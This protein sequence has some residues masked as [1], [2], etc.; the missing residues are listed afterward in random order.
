MEDGEQ[1]KPQANQGE[2]TASPLSPNE[3]GSGQESEAG[4]D[5]SLEQSTEK[6]GGGEEGTQEQKPL[7]SGKDGKLKHGEKS[8]VRDFIRKPVAKIF[9]HKSTE[10]AEALKQGKTRSKSLDRLE[11]PE[12]CAAALDQTDD[13]QATGEAHR[14]AHHSTKHMKRWHSF[15]K[16]MA[17]KGQRRAAEDHKDMDSAEGPGS[18]TQLEAEALETAG[19]L[20]HHGQKRWKLKRSWT[21]QGLKRD[22]SV[23]GIHKPKASDK[24]SLGKGEEAPAN[25]DQGA[26]ASS[27]EAKP[28]AEGETQEREEE[29]GS[30][31]LR[32]KSVDHHAN[33]IWTNFKKRVIP[34]SKRASDAGGG[35]GDEATG[36]HE[37][38]EEATGKSA[39]T[40]RTHFN[41]AVSLKNFIMRKGKSASVDLG[42][43][44]PAEQKE[45]G[46]ESAGEASA[47][48]PVA[49]DVK[50][51]DGPANQAAVKESEAPAAVQNGGDEK[52][53]AVHA[54]GQPSASTDQE[55]ENPDAKEQA[56]PEPAS[57]ET[58]AHEENGSLGAGCI[59]KGSGTD[60]EDGNPKDIVVH[61]H[62]TIPH[63]DAPQETANQGDCNSHKASLQA[64]NA[65]S[66]ESKDEA[67]FNQEQCPDGKPCSGNPVAESEKL[68]EKVKPLK[69]H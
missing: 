16:M 21:F 8:S 20:D 6:E 67:S 4:G 14:P 47:S 13:S 12:A 15:K 39:K 61:D 19:K 63:Q 52:V 26:V 49:E 22:P 23:V 45:D 56:Q 32:A 42:G 1:E 7:G 66:T 62:E 34:K 53:E 25:E 65:C 29:K 3:H 48:A 54:N 43:E 10:K 50:E 69:E 5:G 33:E 60:G 51:G 59:G 64:E 11:D 2:G 36:E 38:A 28:A 68:A 40:K 30:A 31:V 9:S 24:D 37:H 18:D 35:G 46:A 41:R 58:K 17:Q 27:E 44:A 57:G 55:P